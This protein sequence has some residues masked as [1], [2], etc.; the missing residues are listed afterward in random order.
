MALVQMCLHSALS[1]GWLI[2]KDRG[3]AGE[4]GQSLVPL[5]LV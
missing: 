1:W 2:I 3:E 5:S 4:Q